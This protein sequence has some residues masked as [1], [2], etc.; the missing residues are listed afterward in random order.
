VPFKDLEQRKAR[1]KE[2][3]KSW[4]EKNRGQHIARVAKNNRARRDKWLEFKSQLSCSKCGAKHPA[5]IDFHH[6]I[7]DETYRSVFRLASAG[8]LAAAIEET[9]KC[10]P[11]CAN[12]HRILHFDE[13][14]E[15]KRRRRKKRKKKKKSH[16][17]P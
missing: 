15:R 11:L 14:A 1:Q 7:R 4:Y 10:I 8:R 2:Y 12:C 6:V 13:T 9:K 16:R 5:I 17:S 3:S